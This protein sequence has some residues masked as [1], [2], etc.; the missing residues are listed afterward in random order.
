MG[1]LENKPMLISHEIIYRYVWTDKQAEDVSQMAI[2]LL[3]PGKSLVHTITSDSDE[4]LAYHDNISPALCADFYFA[5]FYG[6][7]KREWNEN[8]NGLLRQGCLK[9]ADFKKINQN[10]VSFLVR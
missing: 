5:N 1:T 4:A 3:V 6:S 9:I 8:T 10:E 2:K 7:W